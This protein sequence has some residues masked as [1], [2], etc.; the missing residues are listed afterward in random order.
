MFELYD[1]LVSLTEDYFISTPAQFTASGNQFIFPLPDGVTSFQNGLNPSITF[2]PRA[3]YK[4]IGVDLA[5]NNASNAFV[6]VNKFNFADRN[7][8]VYPNTA[9]TIY[10]VFNLRYRLIGTSS[11]EF[12]P[13][14]SGNQQIRLWYV[15]RL[16]QLLL[17]TDVTD[18]SISGWIEYV[19]VKAA[20]YALAK[21]ESDTSNMEKQ[22]ASL[23]M[24]IEEAASNRDQ[25]NPN[26]ISDSRRSGPWGNGW[27]GGNNGAIGGF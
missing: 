13:T 4:L 6:T 1:L 10:G 26:T 24:R 12:I 2:V 9:S 25:G 22:L 21:E 7:N 16:Q 19:I 3:A 27:S 17:D 11:I 18:M 8:F 20:Y 14:P 5:L 15:P 23:K